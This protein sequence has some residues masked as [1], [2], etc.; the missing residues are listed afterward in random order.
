MLRQK[1]LPT[2]PKNEFMILPESI[3]RYWNEPKHEVDRAVGSLNNFSIHFILSGSGYIEIDGEAFLLKRGDAFL[4]FPMQQQRYYSSQDDPWDIRW[5]HFYGSVLQQFLTERGFHHF[6]LWNVQQLT[7]LEESH[8]KLL[9]KTEQH[10]LLQ[11]SLLST[12]TYSFLMEFTTNA[13]PRSNKKTELDNR[14]E[15]LLPIMQARASEPFDLDYWA[16]SID[17]STYYFCRLFKRATQMTPMT[18]V[19]LC[20]LQL[21]KQLLLDNKLM[22]IKEVAES[23]GYPS[24]SY[25][26][27]RFLEHEGMT[28]TEYRQLYH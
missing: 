28:P 17:V 27:K 21:S 19:T 12:L 22:P 26:N 3:G 2:L 5:V 16:N 13:V 23:A 8:E 7:S 10:S 6:S 15:T 18:F 9:S 24:I 1:L 14:I 25:F 11:L 4:Y 20:R